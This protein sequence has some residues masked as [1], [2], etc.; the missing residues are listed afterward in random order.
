MYVRVFINATTSSCTSFNCQAKIYQ[1]AALKQQTC[2]HISLCFL[3]QKLL[4]LLILLRIFKGDCKKV[5]KLPRFE[6][7]AVYL[8]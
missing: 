3:F 7:N 5:Y 4:G 8:W 2:W 1:S 6:E